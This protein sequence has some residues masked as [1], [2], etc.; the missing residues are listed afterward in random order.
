VVTGN[1][2]FYFYKMDGSGSNA[3]F[4]NM[5]SGNQ[6]KGVICYQTD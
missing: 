3:T 5:G 2:N 4:A 1:N 6:L